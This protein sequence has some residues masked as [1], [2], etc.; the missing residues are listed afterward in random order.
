[1]GTETK[2]KKKIYSI[3][4][5]RTVFAIGIIIYHF[6]CHSKSDFLLLSQYANGTWG[7]LIVTVFFILSGGMLYRNNKKITSVPEFYKKRFLSLFP[8]FYLAYLIFFVKNA[9]VAGK[10]FYGPSAWTLLLTLIGMDGYTEFAIPNYYILG[11]WFFGAIVMMYLIYPLLLLVI[12]KGPFLGGLFFIFLYGVTLYLSFGKLDPF[13]HP[14]SCL[15][16]FYAGML[17]FKYPRFLKNRIVLIVSSVALFVLL[18]FPLPVPSSLS[19]HLSGLASF[20]VLFR[21]GMVV[22]KIPFFR[23]FFAITGKLSYPAYLLQHA[24][25]LEFFRPVN[26]TSA[27]MYLFVLFIT[28]VMIFF[29]AFLLFMLQRLLSSL[30]NTLTAPFGR[31][32]ASHRERKR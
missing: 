11:E 20:I 7:D 4:F 30:W 32:P 5:M 15:I 14:F 17:L 6:S 3:E 21:I 16:S 13:R 9:I 2:P 28:I 25:I 19:A 8:M 31:R 18:F 24:I 22:V 29:A 1:M 27:G 12:R 26:P 10:L 23:M